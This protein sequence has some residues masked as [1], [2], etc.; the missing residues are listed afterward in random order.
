MEE[1]FEINELIQLKYTRML[2][3][4]IGK[5]PGITLENDELYQKI[6][7]K[8]K[9]LLSDPDEAFFN[10]ERGLKLAKELESAMKERV[11]NIC[12]HYQIMKD[13]IKLQD[14]TIREIKKT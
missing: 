14:Q 2:Y 12:E 10:A 1:D 6:D 13:M 11:V 8:I 5:N 7:L 4:L 3:V 9:E